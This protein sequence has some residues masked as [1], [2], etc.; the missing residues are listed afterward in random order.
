MFSATLRCGNSAYDWNTMAIC[1]AAG[2]ASVTSSLPMAMR[3]LL[4]R[5]S[6][7]M[8]RKVVDLPQPDGPSSTTSVPTPASKLTSSTAVTEPQPC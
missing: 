3:P 7:A 2:G 6:P 4:T 1:R 8:R 5:S